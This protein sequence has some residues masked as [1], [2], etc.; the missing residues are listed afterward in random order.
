[1]VDICVGIALTF[2]MFSVFTA[3]FNALVATK[4]SP[5]IVVLK[6]LTPLAMT[7][8]TFVAL[9]GFTEWAW[10]HPGYVI[11]M[12]C[13]LVSL[14][15]SRQIVCNVADQPMKSVPYPPLW[16]LLFVVNTVMELGISE[17]HLAAFVFAMTIGWYL[18]F[19]L[20]T[21]SQICEVCDIWC[22]SIKPAHLKRK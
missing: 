19:A 2:S 3:I 20:G 10:S 1:M 16:Y 14:I 18:H 4:Y 5:R 21:I 7:M 22:L 9:F 17:A 12:T 11:I 13:P 6:G 8:M 15:N